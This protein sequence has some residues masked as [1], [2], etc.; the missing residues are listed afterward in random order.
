MRRRDDEDLALDRL[1]AQPTRG[2]AHHHPARARPPA[3][4]RPSV[5]ELQAEL[6]QLRER[7]GRYPDH[8]VDQLHAARSARA[9]AQRVADEALVRIDELE[10]PARGKP[11]GRR[12]DSTE[13]A[14]ERQRLKL[15]EDQI[16]VSAERE[17][18]LASSVP[19]PAVW[20]AER[21]VLRERAAELHAQLSTRRPSTCTLRSTDQPPTSPWCWAL[22]L[23]SRAVAASGSKPPRASRPTASTT[24]SPTPATHSDHPPPPRA[25]VRTGNAPTTTLSEPSETSVAASTAG[26]PTRSEKPRSGAARRRS[27]SSNSRKW[28]AIKRGAGD[29]SFRQ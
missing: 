10:L 15:A 6:A 26:T 22:P 1:D 29:G 16:A 2:R 28:S 20:D 21:R 9:D 19:D 27:V 14:L 12:A 3:V 4:M 23:T 17:R 5:G 11:G 13:R 18:D 7:I 8:L 25:S 24:P